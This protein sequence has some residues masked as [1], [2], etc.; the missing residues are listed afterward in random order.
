MPY[1]LT[2][3]CVVSHH[4]KLVSATIFSKLLT[5]FVESRV[6][7][8]VQLHATPTVCCDLTLLCF[9]CS[10][11]PH[12]AH[13]QCSLTMLTHTM[14]THTMLTPQCSLAVCWLDLANA[15]GS[16][17]HSLIQFSVEH[18]HAPPCFHQILQALYSDL[19]GK[20]ITN[21]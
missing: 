3:H 21:E 16:V 14:L 15:Y 17:H 12:N 19:V 9:A 1:V 7:R 4:D 10:R 11:S 2:L 8:F 13:P 6:M 18:Y 5:T 20:V